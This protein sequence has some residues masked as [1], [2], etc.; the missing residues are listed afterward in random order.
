ML[1][2]IFHTLNIVIVT[3]K[4]GNSIQTF[5]EICPLITLLY[6]IKIMTMLNAYKWCDFVDIE[7]N[8]IM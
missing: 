6:P 2:Y 8:M 1:D 4:I 5:K 3:D 7:Y